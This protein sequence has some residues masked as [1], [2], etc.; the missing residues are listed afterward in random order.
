M[1]IPITLVQWPCGC[2]ND[3]SVIPPHAEWHLAYECPW[4]DACFT[5]GDMLLWMQ[6]AQTLPPWIVF[7]RP[8]LRVGEK[9][10]ELGEQCDN[11][12]VPYV[13][14]RKVGAKWRHLKVPMAQVEIL[15]D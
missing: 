13:R 9:V 4:C 11:C 8:L 2:M 6:E 3:G 15:K 7:T 14:E 5:R 12:E 1:Q 10:V